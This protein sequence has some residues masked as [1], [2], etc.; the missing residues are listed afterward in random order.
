M[1][2]R[3]ATLRDVRAWLVML[4]SRLPLTMSV[5]EIT[6]RARIDAPMLVAK[7]PAAAFCT[8]AMDA[9]ISTHRF[10]T[11]PTS[12]EIIAALDAWWRENDPNSADRIPE[13]IANAEVGDKGRW[14]I[15]GW[16]AKRD[17]AGLRFLRDH[18][19]AAY[20]WLTNNDTE[21]AGIALTAG[22]LRHLP[23]QVAAS[24]QDEDAISNTVARIMAPMPD[25]SRWTGTAGAL[26]VMRAA[27]TAHAPHN[28]YLVPEWPSA[29]E[30]AL[31]GEIIPPA[32]SDAGLFGG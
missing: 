29:L 14:L 32:S 11:Y 10:P 31:E 5:D 18:H 7:L 21:A 25:G 24:W 17:V 6:Q 4:A 28:L 1:A 13:W 2:D 27:L 3:K 23:Q 9:I 15:K 12:A 20:A 26:D 16:D 22:W 8:G 19:R 30:S